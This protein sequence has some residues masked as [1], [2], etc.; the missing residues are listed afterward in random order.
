MLFWLCDILVCLD[1]SK[2]LLLLAGRRKRTHLQPASF[3]LSEMSPHHTETAGSSKP[4]CFSEQKAFLRQ[5]ERVS[6]P[7]R[8]GSGAF[9]SANYCWPKKVSNEM[10]GCNSLAQRREVADF[11]KNILQQ[12]REIALAISKQLDEYR[13]QTISAGKNT[14]AMCKRSVLRVSKQRSS[15]QKTNLANL[16]LGLCQKSGDILCRGGEVLKIT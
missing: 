13:T 2:Q 9:G 5:H 3:Q 6:T 14:A 12:N 16:L 7:A 15:G 11:F 1:S 4:A 8:T 10:S